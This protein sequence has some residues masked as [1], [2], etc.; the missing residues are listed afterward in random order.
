[1]DWSVYFD[2]KTIVKKQHL[3]DFIGETLRPF[4]SCSIYVAL[5]L[6]YHKKQ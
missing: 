1:M 2:I 3:Y 6:P 4:L 5:S